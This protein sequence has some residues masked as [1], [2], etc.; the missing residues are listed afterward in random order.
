M[1]TIDTRPNIAAGNEPFDPIGVRGG[2]GQ[3]TSR[4]P[5]MSGQ[6]Q[7]GSGQVHGSDSIRATRVTLAHDDPVD[8]AWRALG[9]VYDPELARDVVS[10]GLVY[11]IRVEDS[12]V[13]V[14]MTLSTPDC[15]A[16]ESLPV[17]AK[18]AIRDVV[19]SDALVEVN[20]L[21]DPPWSPAM[22]QDVAAQTLGFRSR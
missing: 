15:P 9:Y 20:V 10:L 2:D 7:S 19:G 12:T 14:D 5:I 13:V 16:S 22:I 6:V 1:A 18:M 11:D 17:L 21:W 8:A 4:Y 3:A